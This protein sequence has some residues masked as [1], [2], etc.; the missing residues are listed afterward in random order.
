MN[1][2]GMFRVNESKLEFLNAA[3]HK[4]LYKKG[5]VG[6]VFAHPMSLANFGRLLARKGALPKAA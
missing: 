2:T 3:Q 4:N 1:L 6:R 5:I